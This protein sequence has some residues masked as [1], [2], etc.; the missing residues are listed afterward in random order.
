MT[1]EDGRKVLLKPDFTWEYLD[2]E[3]PGSVAM[4]KKD[5]PENEAGEGCQIPSD[6]KEPK[7]ST[8]IQNQLIRG[9]ATISDV[10]EKVAKDNEV[11]V[12]EVILLSA[13][14]Q[15]SKGEYRF[16]VKGKEQVYKRI[17]NAII[18]KGDLF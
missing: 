13:S 4:T 8:K 11:P 16:C 5:L 3:A 12:S 9:H 7:L 2:A 18:K 10:K 15:K 14:E 1:T 6:Y 17:G